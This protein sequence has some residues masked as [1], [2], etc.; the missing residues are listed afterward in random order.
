MNL[1]Q[2][3]NIYRELRL[4]EVKNKQQVRKKVINPTEVQKEV[5]KK[6]VAN[7]KTLRVKV[8]SCC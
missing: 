8:D 7:L 1:S 3:R 6:D 2:K 4:L 5:P